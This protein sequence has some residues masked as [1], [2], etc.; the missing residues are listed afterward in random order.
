MSDWAISVEEEVGWGLSS[1]DRMVFKWCFG[2]LAALKSNMNMYALTEL[3][4]SNM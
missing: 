2:E 4:L 1:Y 3:G